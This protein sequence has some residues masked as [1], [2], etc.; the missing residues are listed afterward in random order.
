MAAA[1]GDAARVQILAHCGAP[2]SG[3]HWRKCGRFVVG[4][5]D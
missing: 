4:P 2:D 1:L 3:S 5:G